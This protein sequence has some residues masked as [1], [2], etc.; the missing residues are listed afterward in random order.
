MVDGVWKGAS[1]VFMC[2]RQLL[3]NKFFD[4]RSH[5]IRKGCDKEEEKWK[6]EKNGEKSSPLTL[7][8]VDNLNGDGLQCRRSCHFVFIISPVL[9]IPQKTMRSML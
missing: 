8:P 7:L 3:L 2:S 1:D 4:L 5:F 9:F 6:R